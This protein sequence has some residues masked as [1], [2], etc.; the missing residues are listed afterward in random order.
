MSA[1][2]SFLSWL[3]KDVR[4]YTLL[5]FCQSS[6]CFI[7]MVL[8]WSWGIWNDFSFNDFQ[9]C[10][11]PWHLSLAPFL[12]S[13]PQKPGA[14]LPKMDP[15]NLFMTNPTLYSLKYKFGRN[16]LPPSLGFQ[17]YETIL[18]LPPISPAICWVFLHNDQRHCLGLYL[19]P[20]FRFHGLEGLLHSMV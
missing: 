18:V 13:S 11:L 4:I 14:L 1:L 17:K 15:N 16:H 12:S 9:E 7:H 20:L 5:I 19:A 3:P 10:S 6:P 2:D 8:R